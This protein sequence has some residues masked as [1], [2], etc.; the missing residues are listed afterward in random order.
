MPDFFLFILFSLVLSIIA[1]NKLEDNVAPC[2]LSS[3]TN[4]TDG[5]QQQNDSIFPA[6]IKY[7]EKKNN[8]KHFDVRV[9]EPEYTRRSLCEM[10]DCIRVCCDYG[11]VLRNQE[12]V[13]YYLHNVQFKSSIESDLKANKNVGFIYGKPCKAM[14]LR[15][16]RAVTVKFELLKVS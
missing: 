7:L 16:E 1:E 9:V 3:A 5:K 4:I 6:N 15:D 8:I 13:D 14:V 2:N 12:C 11:K 10:K